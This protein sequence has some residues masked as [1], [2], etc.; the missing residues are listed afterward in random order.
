MSYSSPT[1]TPSSAAWLGYGGLLP[2]VVLAIAVYLL[3]QHGALLGRSLLAYGAVILSFVGALHW[4]FAM[5]LQGLSARQR[6]N[7]YLWS[8]V[9]ALL[10]WLALAMESAALASL[11]LVSGF[12]ANYWRDACLTRLVEMP[13][14]YLPLRLRLTVVACVCLLAFAAVS[15]T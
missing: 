13:H 1:S 9:P 14:W 7:A 2:F 15:L 6:P 5:T 10:A 8:V 11:L 12:G 3:P 4:G